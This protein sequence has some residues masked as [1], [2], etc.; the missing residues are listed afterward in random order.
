MTTG[1]FREAFAPNPAQE[2]L[3]RRR[4][5]LRHNSLCGTKIAALIDRR[6]GGPQGAAFA[7]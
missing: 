7:L 5:F 1:A 2:Q 3:F 4:K 6:P